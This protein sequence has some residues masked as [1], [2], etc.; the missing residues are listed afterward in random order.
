MVRYRSFWVLVRS[1]GE[2]AS[3]V[4]WRLNRSGFPTIVLELPS[5]LVVRRRVAFAEAVFSGECE[6]EGIP[7][8]LVQ[9]L[10]EAKS[11]IEHAGGVPV[12]I[13]PDVQVLPVLSP[14]VLIDGRMAKRALDTRIGQAPIVIGLGPGFTAGV[15]ADAVIETNSGPSLGRVIYEGTALPNTGIPC[16]IGGFQAERVLRAPRAGMF[17][18]EKEIGD[19]VGKGE[20]VGYVD[21]APVRAGVGGVLWGLLHPGI[22][23]DEGTK[24]GDIDPRGD[25]TVVDRIAGKGQAVAAGTL[26]AIF[27][28]AA[29]KEIP[30]QEEATP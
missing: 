9:D 4:V 30:L 12:L 17:L 2:I 22:H 23:V 6:V 25:P 28:L 13:D 5:P 16:Q 7:G 29:R 1:G 10:A 18:T 19:V 14:T 3:A 8:K 26:A 15:H 24:L 27:T 11:Y 21:D 20:I